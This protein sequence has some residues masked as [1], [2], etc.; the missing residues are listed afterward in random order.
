MTL[1]SLGL[2]GDGDEWA[3]VAR[4]ERAFDVRLDAPGWRSVGDVHASLLRALPEARRGTDETWRHF[5]AAIAAETGVDPHR[6]GPGTL[7]LAVPLWDLVGRGLRRR[8]G[9]SSGSP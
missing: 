8:L 5:A 4:V 2:G 6:V 9:R 7:L 3:A 1:E